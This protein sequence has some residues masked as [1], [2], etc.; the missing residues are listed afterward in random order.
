VIRRKT[1]FIASVCLILSLAVAIIVLHEPEP[2]YGG[3]SLTEWLQDAAD[4]GREDELTRHR[5][6]VQAMGTNCIPTL[7]E[8][9]TYETPGWK[10]QMYAIA[11]RVSGRYG[12]YFRDRDLNNF[13]LIGFYLLG[14][15]GAAAI[16]PLT[17]MMLSAED[18]EGRRAAVA[19]S[20]IGVDAIPALFEGLTNINPEVRGFATYYG[21]NYLGTNAAPAIP[22]IV[23]RLND[24]DDT[25]RLRTVLTLKHLSI[26]PQLTVPAFVK[27]FG[28]SNKFVRLAAAEGL[29][30]FGTNAV[31]AEPALRALIDDPDAEVREQ[32]K[33]TLRKILPPAEPNVSGE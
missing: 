19:L 2:S 27:C 3:K 12:V 11:N 6:A 26:E 17:R 20:S 32:V 33:I 18:P 15:D 16:P 24:P 29:A 4:A 13:A 30:E 31:A 5:A 8:F 14:S 9:L 23:E 10:Q 21:W 22:Y 25:E 28:D 1:V 7:M